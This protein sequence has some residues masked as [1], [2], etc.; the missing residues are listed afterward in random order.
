MEVADIDSFQLIELSREAIKQSVPRLVAQ[1]LILLSSQRLAV[2]ANP[3]SY[4]LEQVD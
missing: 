1:L 3:V 2:L 4:P